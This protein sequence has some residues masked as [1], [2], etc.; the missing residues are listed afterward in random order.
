M[1]F[2]VRVLN[3]ANWKRNMGFLYRAFAYQDSLQIQSK[4]WFQEPLLKFEKEMQ[5]NIEQ[6]FG[7]LLK[8]LMIWDLTENDL[9]ARID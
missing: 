5:K 2:T 7:V 4:F 8:N 9:L 1:E 6:I 3:I